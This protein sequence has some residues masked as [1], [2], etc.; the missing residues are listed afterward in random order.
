MCVSKVALLLLGH[1]SAR[2]TCA[3][4][5]IMI[6][7]VLAFQGVRRGDSVWGCVTWHF[8]CACQEWWLFQLKCILFHKTHILSTKMSRR[9]CGLALTFQ[10]RSRAPDGPTVP[11]IVRLPQ[12]WLRWLCDVLHAVTSQT[13]GRCVLSV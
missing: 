5:T 2:F 10:H 3:L 1:M 6:F 13:G 8:L 9:V 12:Y 7:M 11:Y 4:K